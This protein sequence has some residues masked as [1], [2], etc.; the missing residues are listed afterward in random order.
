MTPGPEPCGLQPDEADRAARRY[1]EAEAHAYQAEHGS[2]L[3]QGDAGGP[4]FVWGPEGLTESE[5]QLL[6]PIDAL[7]GRV[8]LE[9]GCGAAQCS[10][11][12]ADRGVRAVGIDIATA[13]VRQARG[14]VPLVA[15]S[16]ASLPFRDHSVDTAFSAYGAVQFVADLDAL[17]AAVARVLRP[18][19]RLVFSVTHPVRWAFPDEPGPQG[20]RATGDYFDRTPYVERSTVDGRALYAEFHRTVADYVGA[21]LGAG[22]AVDAV[23]EPRW[24]QWNRTTW[25]GWSPLR[26]RHLPGTLIIGAAR[27]AGAASCP[28][29]HP[30][31]PIR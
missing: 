31:P 21:L 29:A 14:T 30:G 5:A 10:R 8:V 15:G 24:P 6:G 4:G 25:G 12:L 22:F 26:G 27:T 16:A 28:D 2:F 17:F 13:Q 18:G 9:L 3:G 19:G 7:V 20:L 1:W 23:V 11:W